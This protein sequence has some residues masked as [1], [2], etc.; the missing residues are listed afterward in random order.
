M[1]DV[2]GYVQFPLNVDKDMPFADYEIHDV[3]LVTD[4]AKAWTLDGYFM[5]EWALEDEV[6]PNLHTGSHIDVQMAEEVPA[7]VRG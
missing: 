2:P 4:G 5:P 6:V 7:R 3:G 1:M